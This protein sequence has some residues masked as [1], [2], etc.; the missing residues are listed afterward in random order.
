MSE[1]R[2]ETIRQ[3]P[4]PETVMRRDSPFKATYSATLELLDREIENVDGKAVVIQMR[5]DGS[6]IRLDGGLRASARPDMPGVILTFTTPRLGKVRFMCDRF[7]DWQHNLR[8]IALGMEAL[9]KIDRYGI[10]SDGQQYEGFKALSAAEGATGFSSVEDAA[11]FIAETAGAPESAVSAMLDDPDYA[12]MLY[13]RAAKAA[14]PDT[15][16]D[17]ATMARLTV[18]RAML[19]EL[20]A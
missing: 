2:V 13:R 17:E 14:H 9:R 11:V 5:L 15:G 3:W 20:H 7:Y 1:L 10:T 19:E 8:A 18:A 6:G 12:A 16:G 4:G